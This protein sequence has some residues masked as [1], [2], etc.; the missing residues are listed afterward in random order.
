MTRR[1]A[2]LLL[3]ANNH[4]KSDMTMIRIQALEWVQG[5]IQDIILNNVTTDWP[6][7]D[8]DDASLLF[9]ITFELSA[10]GLAVAVAIEEYYYHKNKISWYT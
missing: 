3:L 2:L 6:F 1:Q 9:Y 4:Y 10:M 7:Y 5:Q 8:N